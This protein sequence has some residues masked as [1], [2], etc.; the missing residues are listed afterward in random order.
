MN[1]F[2]E[3]ENV[4]TLAVNEKEYVLADVKSN[5]TLANVLRDRIGLTGTKVACDEG[6]CGACTVLIDGVP[7]LSCMTLAHTAAGKEITTIEGLA[8]GNRLHPIQEAFVEERGFACGYC[9]PGFIMTTKALLAE[10]PNP[11]AQAIKDA[12][13]GN[14]C[15]CAVY[16][17]IVL[18]VQKAARKLQEVMDHA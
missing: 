13:A 5:E 11:G 4:L 9:T 8:C 18:S 1:R 10:N 14:I 6:A 16:E 3:A 17:H 7:I 12:L 2:T 15:R